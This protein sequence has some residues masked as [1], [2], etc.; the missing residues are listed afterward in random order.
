MQLLIFFTKKEELIDELMKRLAIAGVKGGTVLEST[1]M[2]KSLAN[3]D[4]MPMFDIFKEIVKTQNESSKTILLGVDENKVQDVRNIV[5]E[6]FGDLSQ[7]N[8]GVLMG[9]PLSF[10]DG[11]D[12]HCPQKKSPKVES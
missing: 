5:S 11:V 12:R 3:V 7:P 2:A 1:G 10:A 8:T 4:G 6:V 9:I